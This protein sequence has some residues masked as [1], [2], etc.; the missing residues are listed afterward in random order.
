[1][2][3]KTAKAIT[4]DHVISFLFQVYCSPK[5]NV[6]TVCLTMQSKL[7]RYYIM[8]SSLKYYYVSGR[9]LLFCHYA[10]LK[11]SALILLL[12]NQAHLSINFCKA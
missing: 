7:F 4:F 9:M 6:H 8:F 1:M 5:A 2:E 3:G 12:R 11:L 10:F